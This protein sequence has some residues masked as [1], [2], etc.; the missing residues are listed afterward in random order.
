MN[1]TTLR[2]TSIHLSHKR[3]KFFLLFTG[4][5]IFF[6]CP[7]VTANE[8]IEITYSDFPPFSI[9]SERKDQPN[10]LMVD[11]FAHI[12]HQSNINYTFK[13]NSLKRS[14]LAIRSGSATIFPTFKHL[15]NNQYYHT[16]D[17]P[18]LYLK[19]NLYW[20]KGTKPVTHLQDLNDTELGVMFG[21]SYD[22]RIDTI[23][24]SKNITIRPIANPRKSLEILMSGRVD[25]LL[26][27]ESS[28]NYFYSQ[29]Q[30]HD[31]ENTYAGT[32]TQ[33][34]A[35][36]KTISDAKEKLDHLEQSSRI[37]NN[38]GFVEILLERYKK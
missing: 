13:F 17:E 27:Y 6:Y 34:L 12:L 24:P 2:L 9:V 38:N 8:S 10:G 26:N 5:I 28:M 21:Y 19:F 4:I 1:Q 37:A 15:V 3:F 33:Y 35:I 20:K 14:L 22:N 32:A 18:I 36:N 29:E 16:T 31:T 25:Y 7:L 23:D 30:M 11:Y